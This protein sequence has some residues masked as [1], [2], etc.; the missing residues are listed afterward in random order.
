MFSPVLLPAFTL[1]WHIQV[2]NQINPFPSEWCLPV[3]AVSLRAAQHNIHT[4]VLKEKHLPCASSQSNKT[5]NRLSGLSDRLARLN[6]TSEWAWCLLWFFLFP[7][8]PT[9][10]NLRQGD[11]TALLSTSMSSSQGCEGTRSLL[12]DH[13]S[14]IT[15]IY[16]AHYPPKYSLGVHHTWWI[17]S[18]PGIF[19]SAAFVSPGLHRCLQTNT[20]P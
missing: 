15:V 5:F 20:W 3:S 4:L 16:I 2:H 11:V 19:D 17:L 10:T 18:S 14:T 12:L 13:S 9:L 8:P 1:L 6:L 7:F